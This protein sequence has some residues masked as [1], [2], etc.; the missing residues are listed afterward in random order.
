MLFGYGCC[1]FQ[2][3]DHQ[4]H[5]TTD[6][7]F[8]FGKRTVDHTGTTRSADQP[9]LVFERLPFHCFALSS[10]LVVPI[11][12][13][14]NQLLTLIWSER[15]KNLGSS[16]PKYEQVRLWHSGVGFIPCRAGVMRP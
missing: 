16:I 8:G 3:L 1:L 11:V 14:V 2:S 15:L 5:E 6:R 10:E 7:F 12:P 9:R 13:A 4:F